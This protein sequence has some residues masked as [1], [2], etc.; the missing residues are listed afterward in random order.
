MRIV[1]ASLAVCLLLIMFARYADAD[2]MTGN[3]LKGS[4][5]NKEHEPHETIAVG[6][7]MGVNDMLRDVT[8]CTP[9]DV[10][11]RQLVDII[12]K[13]LAEHPEQLHKGA[14]KLIVEALSSTFPCRK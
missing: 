5:D 13:Y 8:A 3:E 14:S 2:F 1:L 6:Y 10:T 9:N 12:R 4:F 7:I 11:V